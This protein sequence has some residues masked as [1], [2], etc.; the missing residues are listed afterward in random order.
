[1]VYCLLVSSSSRSKARSSTECA[2]RLKGLSRLGR[3]IR[4]RTWRMSFE[5][6]IGD[7]ASLKMRGLV[8]ARSSWESG[9]EI[10]YGV[11][12]QAGKESD[13]RGDEIRTCLALFGG[14]GGVAADSSKS[15]A[16]TAVPTFPL[17]PEACRP[18]HSGQPRKSD[19]IDP[20]HSL[21]CV[22]TGNG[23]NR[24]LPSED[25]LAR[26]SLSP[27]RVLAAGRTDRGLAF[28]REDRR[29]G[30]A[31]D[32]AGV[33][34]ASSV[35]VFASTEGGLGRLSA[36]AAISPAPAVTSPAPAAATVPPVEGSD[37]VPPVVFPSAAG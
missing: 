17:E 6:V 1:M 29:S 2:G 7:G 36:R 21:T 24:V 26:S 16:L 30:V 13:A 19:L 34:A 3:L 10:Q 12:G 32:I 5:G 4:G 22:D 35:P 37:S 27:G 25:E 31:V 14:L 9:T 28:A 33:G 11:S 20:F 8:G 18:K 15:G 23:A